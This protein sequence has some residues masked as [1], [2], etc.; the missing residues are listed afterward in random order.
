[1]SGIK[2]DNNKV[3]LSLLPKVA[4]EEMAKAMMHGAK[5][6]GRNNYT[7]GMEATRIIAAA[8][9]H[10]TAYNDGQDTDEESGVSH[11]GHAMACCLMLL[12]QEQ[13]GTLKDNRLAAEQLADTNQLAG[14]EYK[15]KEIELQIPQQSNGL[16]IAPMPVVA[17]KVTNWNPKTNTYTYITIDE[18]R[19]SV[20]SVNYEE[21]GKGID[22][23]GTFAL[24]G[25]L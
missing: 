16:D 1:M 20:S 10:I 15:P 11:L 6:Y 9:R 5:K 22:N 12:H 19:G 25:K 17:S 13:L 21:P 14:T 7:K 2:F 8:L 18:K 4:L 24:G 23:V 3:D